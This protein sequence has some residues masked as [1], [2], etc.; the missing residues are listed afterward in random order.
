[1]LFN[2]YCTFTAGFTKTG[3][4]SYPNIIPLLTGKRTRDEQD[5]MPSE[6]PT[7]VS[8]EDLPIVWKQFAE[9]GYITAMNEDEQDLGLFHFEQPGFVKKPVDFYY[10]QYWI[11]LKNIQSRQFNGRLCFGEKSIADIHLEITRNFVKA[12]KNV[13]SFMYHF[14][15]SPTHE[16]PMMTASLDKPYANFFQELH[17]NGFFNKT[18]IVFFAD[19][20]H[21]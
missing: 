19:H 16:D 12:F 7:P 9:K 20:G 1:M 18:M 4:N 11:H 13:A 3:D 6:I 14:L 21:R 10:H 2:F 5:D 15:I 17:T 8:P